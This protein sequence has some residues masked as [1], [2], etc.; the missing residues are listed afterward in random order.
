[1]LQQPRAQLYAQSRSR[2]YRRQGNDLAQLPAGVKAALPQAYLGRCPVIA[3]DD[4]S[5]TVLP[6]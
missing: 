1:V 4:A 3:N 5:L 2:I 6:K